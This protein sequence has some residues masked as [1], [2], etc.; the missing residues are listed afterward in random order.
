MLGR[1][2]NMG[3]N[4][5][6]KKPRQESTSMTDTARKPNRLI[7]E[8]SPYLK[9]HAYN[10]V[11][12]FPWG[13]EALHTAKRLDWPIFL[14]I[15]YSA[16]HWCHVMEHESFEDP[17][18]AK[19][20]S[21]H[22]ISIKVDREERPDLDQIYMTAVQILTRHGGW[23]M[24]VFLTPDLQPF[25][26]GTYFPP[27]D[28]HGMPSFKR[29]LL[30]LADAWKNRRTDIAANA[31]QITAGIQEAMQLEVPTGLLTAELLR[32]GAQML[33]RAFD[34]RFGGFGQAPKFPHPMELRLLL[35][36]AHRLKDDS[37]LEMATKT[38]DHMALGGMYDQLG[39]GFHRYST[40]ERWLVP[41][42]EK[43]LY[44][45]ALLSLAYLE[46]YQVTN[47]EYYREIVDETL[48]YVLREMTGSSGA[49]FSTQDADSEGV[50]GK[51]FVWTMK[52]IEE[53]MDAG[54]QKCLPHRDDAKLFCSVY[55]VTDAGNWE[56]HNILHLS[57][58]L[59]IEAKMQ[60]L[61]AEE[62][63]ACLKRCKEQLLAVRNRRIWPGR[64][65]KILT[66]WNALMI[67]SFAKAAQVL[68]KSEYAQAA[69]RAADFLLTTMRRPDGRLYR[70][71]LAGSTPKLNAYLDDYAYLID[72]LV[73]LYE[74]TFEPRWIEAA[75]SLTRVMIE[76]FWDEAAGGFFYTGK[77]HEA[78]IARTKDPHDNATPSGNSMAVCALLRLAALTGDADLLEKAKR[79]LHLF[80]GLMAG[81]PMAAGQML[82]ALD[83]QLGPVQE[84]AVVGEA[85]NPEVIA[86]L[87]QLRRQFRPHQVVAWK[88][89]N[90][91]AAAE[92]VPLL[93]NRAALGAVTTYVCENFTC[94]A[95]I[96]GA[97]A[98]S[99][100]ASELE[101][102]A[103]D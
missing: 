58:P 41:H 32:R 83:F 67:A 34:P 60:E 78:L 66:S 8:T 68:E 35:R 16:C 95:P 61:S 63:K 26:G 43:M 81:S 47:K 84:I 46:A 23:P 72:A 44:D 1:Q 29:L 50:E 80:S 82:I 93:K 90:D 37:A 97:K 85:A 13:D 103:R 12:W 45:N 76:Q 54:R 31:T 25:Y 40:D 99:E 21:A 77:D 24:S 36:I 55:D 18:V 69:V 30:A 73:T 62:L 56:E 6:G 92:I 75:L 102:P 74:T 9:Q 4:R 57:R 53:A 20:L 65:E 39:G 22:F 70:T 71:T 27:D 100:W 52:E 86:V 19:I 91:S 51:F 48:A 28:R 5:C 59:E 2:T 33:E 88:A 15:G 98:F 14:S 79:T 64:D 7:H 89:G 96:I 87:R 10:P 101:A 38:L 49:F 11:D 17:E 3:I 94:Q 42:F